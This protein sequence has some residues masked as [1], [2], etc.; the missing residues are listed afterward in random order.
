MAMHMYN[1][2]TCVLQCSTTSVGLTQAHPTLV[3]LTMAPAQTF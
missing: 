2:Y 3:V 1:S